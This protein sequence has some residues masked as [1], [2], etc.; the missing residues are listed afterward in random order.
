MRYLDLNSGG[1]LSVL[2]QG[3]WRMG[4]SAHQRETEVAAL[5]YGLDL[6]LEL[7]DTAEMYGTGGAEIV[8]GEAIAGRRDD[9]FLT[10]KVLPGNATTVR[11]TIEACER[12]LE[13][14]GTNHIDLYLLHWRGNGALTETFEAFERLRTEGKIRYFG[15]SNFD[16]FDMQDLW[17]LVNTETDTNQVLYNLSRRGPEHDLF[18]WCRERGIPLMAYSPIEQGRLL[19]NPA[20]ERVAERHDKTPAQIAVA[21]VLHQP[22]LC[23]IPKAATPEHVADNRAALDIVLTEQDLT[24]LDREFPAPSGPVPLEVL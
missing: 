5:R 23:A 16:P 7:V 18:P 22:M 8:V 24:E 19:G 20:L 13:R 2:G 17:S 10:S 4:E 15:V 12:S 14:L 21:W 6:G 9:V 1:K 11:G 3:T